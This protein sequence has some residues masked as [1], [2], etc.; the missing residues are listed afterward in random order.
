[1][2][3]ALGAFNACP[4]VQTI[5]IPR[6][7]SR[8][9]FMGFAGCG[10]LVDIILPDT[11]LGIG[12]RAFEGCTSLVHLVLPPLLTRI[13]ARLFAGCTN[14]ATI[15]LPRQVRE[16]GPE[17]FSNC[18]SLREVRTDAT[19]INIGTNAFL[20]ATILQFFEGLATAAAVGPFA[21]AD[22]M[23]CADISPDRGDACVAEDV[24]VFVVPVSLE[25][26]APYSFRNCGARSLRVSEA[27][28]Q[29]GTGAFSSN[30]DLWKLVIADGTISIGAAAFEGCTR[31]GSAT[32]PATTVSINSSAFH[33]CTDLMWV[34]FDGRQLP[35]LESDDAGQLAP[36]EE[37]CG[38]ISDESTGALAWNGIMAQVANCTTVRYNVYEHG[39]LHASEIC[40]A[41]DRFVRYA[42]GEEALA[43]AES[44]DIRYDDRQSA[45]ARADDSQTRKGTCPG[46]PA[47]AAIFIDDY[48]SSDRSTAHPPGVCET[49]CD[50]SAVYVQCCKA[51][52]D[53][54]PRASSRVACG[55]SDW[56]P[57]EHC[58]ETDVLV[59]RDVTSLVV[60]A[61]MGCASIASMTLPTTLRYIEREALRDCT[62]LA[63]IEIPASVIRI[64]DR[65]LFGCTSLLGVVFDDYTALG[66]EES[67][68]LDSAY[69]RE[70][71]GGSTCQ[72][73]QSAIDTATI[74]DGEVC[75]A[76]PTACSGV[77]LS[78]EF[79]ACGD[80]TEALHREPLLGQ[81][82]EE[83]NELDACIVTVR[84]AGVGTLGPEE[85]AGTS[86]QRFGQDSNLVITVS[87]LNL[88]DDT[89]FAT[90]STTTVNGIRS[91]GPIEGW[92]VSELPGYL[93]Q[94]CG[95]STSDTLTDT[96]DLDVNVYQLGDL[97][98]TDCEADCIATEDC[99]YF[100]VIK[101]PRLR[102]RDLNEERLDHCLL[103]SACPGK[104]YYAG[105]AL[106]R[107]GGSRTFA[108]SGNT[109]S[110]D[111]SGPFFPIEAISHTT[112]D[113]EEV[114]EMVFQQS[115]QSE[116]SV[117]A[118]G[119]TMSISIFKD[120]GAAVASGTTTLPDIT[121]ADLVDIR[122]TF[123]GARVTL[124][125]C[126]SETT[127]TQAALCTY[128][129]DSTPRPTCTTT[130]GEVVSV[131]SPADLADGSAALELTVG[132]DTCSA[133]KRATSRAPGH[134]DD[135]ADGCMFAYWDVGDCGPLGDDF[136]DPCLVQPLGSFAAN[137]ITDIHGLVG[138]EI[139]SSC[140]PGVGV[141]QIV[142]RWR[143]ECFGV[144]GAAGF[145]DLSNVNISGAIAFEC[146]AAD[147][148]CDAAR[149]SPE[150]CGYIPVRSTLSA[151]PTQ[152]PTGSPA[153]S[154]LQCY[155]TSAPVLAGLIGAVSNLDC[156]LQVVRLNDV[157]QFAGNVLTGDEPLGCLR[158]L[159]VTEDRKFLDGQRAT[160]VCTEVAT[161]IAEFTGVQLEC[162]QWWGDS[163]QDNRA[164]NVLRVPTDTSCESVIRNL[165]LIGLAADNLA[166]NATRRPTSAPTTRR[167][168]RA[169]T[170]TPTDS[171]ARFS[172]AG[173]DY[174]Y[175]TESETE[176]L[177]YR[178]VVTVNCE[179][180]A[181]RLRERVKHGVDRVGGFLCTGPNDDVV[182][183]SQDT[184]ATAEEGMLYST[185]CTR[186]AAELSDATD[187]AFVCGPEGPPGVRQFLMFT[188]ACESA[189]SRLNTFAADETASPTEIPT[190]RPTGSPI[191]PPTGSP[192]PFPSTSPTGQ[193][194]WSPTLSPTS[195]PTPCELINGV[196]E[197][198]DKLTIEQCLFA[199]RLGL[200]TDPVW[201]R[202][203]RFSCT[204]CTVAP[205]LSPT[206][207]PTIF[208]STFPSS[209]PSAS[210]SALPSTL[211]SM[212]PTTEPTMSPTE[213]GYIHARPDIFL[214]LFPKS[215][216][217]SILSLGYCSESTWLTRCS[218]TC[219]GCTAAPTEMPTTTPTKTP[220]ALPTVLPT[221]F[222][223]SSPTILP[224]RCSEIHTDP[225]F[226][227]IMD[228]ST[229]ELGLALGYCDS[230]PH[231][232]ANCRFTCTGC[233]NAPTLS[234]TTS[235]TSAP[236]KC[237][238]IANNPD[239]ADLLSLYSC[240]EAYENGFCGH[241]SWYDVCRWTCTGCTLGPTSSPT[242]S[243]TNAPSVTPTST[244]TGSPT[245]NP[246]P[247]PTNFPTI[248]PTSS[249]SLSPILAPSVFP[250]LSPS[251]V[252]TASPSVA[253]TLSPTQCEEI[254]G[255][256]D[257]SDIFLKT[258]CTR[259]YNEGRCDDITYRDVCRYTCTGCTRAPTALPT[260]FPS[261]LPSSSPTLSPSSTTT[262]TQTRTT[263]TATSLT[264]TSHTATVVTA[265]SVT[266]TSFTITSKTAT[267][268]TQ[269]TLTQTSMTATSRTTSI[270]ATVTSL[271]A[272]SKTA[273]A[274]TS[275][276]LTITS[277]TTSITATAT[278]LTATSKTATA[279]T[280]TSLT[281][282]S[283]T[284]TTLTQTSLSQTS[285]TATSMTA[286]PA[287]RR[288]RRG[289]NGPVPTVSTSTMGTRAR[290]RRQTA[291][292]TVTGL[293][294]AP[295]DDEKCL[296]AS[297]IGQI[298]NPPE[299]KR[300]Y[301][302][303]FPD[304][305]D[306]TLTDNTT[307]TDQFGS[308]LYS[309]DSWSAVVNEPGEWMQIDL[310]AELNIHALVFQSRNCARNLCS[311]TNPQ[312]V[313]RFTVN[314]SS[315]LGEGFTSVASV[316][317][318]D[319]PSGLCE[320]YNFGEVVQARYVRL[321]VEEWS[322]HIAMRAGVVVGSTPN[323]VLRCDTRA[324]GS[325]GSPALH[326]DEEGVLPLL[327]DRGCQCCHV[328]NL[329]ERAVGCILD[330]TTEQ[331]SFSGVRCYK[332]GGSSDRNGLFGYWQHVPDVNRDYA[333]I[334]SALA[335]FVGSI[336]G[337]PIGNPLP[338]ILNDT[339]AFVP[340]VNNWGG[341]RVLLNDCARNIDTLN[342]FIA[343]L[344]V[345]QT[346]LAAFAP[347]CSAPT[348]PF[349]ADTASPNQSPSL[350][351]TLTPSMFPTPCAGDTLQACAVIP[352]SAC[353]G[354]TAT[355]DES[356]RL[357][358]ESCPTLCCDT[359]CGPT[360]P[361]TLSPTVTP[362]SSPSCGANE[363]PDGVD[364]TICEAA[365]DDPIVCCVEL[366][367]NWCQS[368]CCDAPSCAASPTTPSP[369]PAPTS[370]P[371]KESVYRLEFEG[372]LLG[373]KYLPMLP[374]AALG[375]DVIIYRTSFETKMPEDQFRIEDT[376]DRSSP[377]QYVY[378]KLCCAAKMEAVYDVH[379]HL[380][381][382]WFQDGVSSTAGY[383][384]RILGN[385]PLFTRV[386]VYFFR[387]YRDDS[388][389]EV[390]WE[391]AA[392]G[393]EPE[394]DA[395][396]LELRRQSL[397]GPPTWQPHTTRPTS[398]PTTRSP[399]DVT[400]SP[401]LCVPSTTGLPSLLPSAAP[402]T[403]GPTADVSKTFAPTHPPTSVPSV[404]PTV[405]PATF[406]RTCTV[407]GNAEIGLGCGLGE[408]RS[409][410]TGWDA[411]QNAVN[412]CGEYYQLSGRLWYH[413]GVGVYLQ[414]VN[415][416]TLKLLD[417]TIGSD[418]YWIISDTLEANAVVHLGAC[419]PY[420]DSALAILDRLNTA[421]NDEVL[422][423]STCTH[424]TPAGCDFGFAPIT[425]GDAS[426]CVSKDEC[427]P[428][429]PGRSYTSAA[430]YCDLTCF[431]RKDCCDDVRTV[432]ETSPR[433][434]APSLS[435]TSSPTFC[436]PGYQDELPYETC[437]A[438]LADG[439]C[440][441]GSRWFDSCNRTCSGC[442]SLRPTSAPSSAP[443]PCA[444]VFSNTSFRDVLPPDQ[445]NSALRLGYCES[446]LAWYS[447]CNF[448]CTGCTVSPTTSPTMAPTKAPTLAPTESPSGS[449]SLS[450]TLSPTASPTTSP[451]GSPSLSP[452]AD[453][454]VN[455]LLSRDTTKRPK[456][457]APSQR[458]GMGKNH[459]QKGN[460]DASAGLTDDTNRDTTKRPKTAAPSQRIGMGE[461][462]RQKG[463][464][465]AS[466]GLTDDTNR[467]GGGDG[468][469]A[470]TTVEGVVLATIIMVSASLVV[471]GIV[472]LYKRAVSQRYDAASA[473]RTMNRLIAK[474]E[475]N[476]VVSG[477]ESGAE[478]DDDAI[479]QG[480][481][482][483]VWS[484]PQF[485][486]A[487]DAATQPQ[488][489]LGVLA[490]LD[491]ND[492][493]A[494]SRGGGGG[495]GEAKST[496]A[497]AL[498][499]DTP[500][501]GAKP[502]LHQDNSAGSILRL[503]TDLRSDL[504]C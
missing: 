409:Q 32:I 37:V 83:R 25:T 70:I 26:I 220:T 132:R 47:P 268:L 421:P 306:S 335:R 241:S 308:M 354:T 236:S 169:P 391:I 383:N 52:T 18:S 145:E 150:T 476:T 395:S 226:R 30:T 196:E 371:T 186:A 400:P 470:S 205:T 165:E 477:V 324:P 504:S 486:A 103:F 385:T 442:G 337:R 127:P 291:I 490:S 146:C 33:D 290:D 126:F 480:Y 457:A 14:L 99:A 307:L 451:S 90:G 92:L 76:S 199:F 330:R 223:T 129:T 483:T 423:G 465:D 431:I 372:R 491:A 3:L 135:V 412:F 379:W 319:D 419:C 232:L 413:E 235:P 283:R 34:E 166:F 316:S 202:N 41:G 190:G 108:V 344:A 278:S 340:L 66:P 359:V 327:C 481:I 489:K 257:F 121:P 91:R 12:D 310:G 425:C 498:R 297:G 259:V 357:V 230:H 401:T 358:R 432:C 343:N 347:A 7:V 29:I 4:L 163:E 65:A 23:V 242:T 312:R 122:T 153:P 261:M 468:R 212:S 417:G 43:C 287:L 345:D 397:A 188:Y 53:R 286:T 147:G 250:T 369:T 328:V 487:V 471:I 466:A 106:N 201:Y 174:T 87:Q 271:T 229:C 104:T 219:T 191:Q 256:P 192:T 171:D 159:V 5:H 243:P 331:Y 482:S 160:S 134:A 74:T 438:A 204:G 117:T 430:C 38:G 317:A 427:V 233:T 180:D 274:V 17:A 270:T 144:D 346:A 300:S 492:N 172:C 416:T 170:S 80:C 445:C 349:L 181:R 494:T 116:V 118:K 48:L 120:D 139:Y 458:I 281:I 36:F 239:F 123:G 187:L 288:H 485:S 352:S 496:P 221:G 193:P 42:C 6:T 24:S 97:F 88:V 71:F 455:V 329:L 113:S 456:T 495:S 73:I 77:G 377:K 414:R 54:S 304:E 39:P 114:L 155:N 355:I 266:Y 31:L 488:A 332:Q 448:T 143:D 263:A 303:L 484:D 10:N 40:T 62:N 472:L 418:I 314:V 63:R 394:A 68:R 264:A 363:V 426:T 130:V 422:D 154:E 194:T 420:A 284:A 258:D 252:P 370:A 368:A 367:A 237:E 322:G 224:T 402:S 35:Q 479:V 493:A 387:D 13:G 405:S 210:P 85:G 178:E 390:M 78:L 167:P 183:G 216:C 501:G 110:V 55:G 1:M 301:S 305:H 158:K 227:D 251:S 89:V 341:S 388:Q 440:D 452:T 338:R 475:A 443:T 20:G 148:T 200:C 213:C 119:I 175:A 254:D 57:S 211:P 393:E 380:H 361:P 435:P 218:F 474:Q 408:T 500:T 429:R 245:A 95:T 299:S 96:P 189:M 82:I 265:T 59:P 342:A 285:I 156:T 16:I 151:A 454:E 351:P 298:V 473:A 444:D 222:P 8:I 441:V 195:S 69:G 273:T 157:L 61:F 138:D 376:S 244:P 197:F 292:I 49:L 206:T 124:V 447:N 279:V 318:Q 81:I 497:A 84:Y 72:C 133:I 365:L 295:T 459:R 208:P 446:D 27:V 109:T 353:C 415:F 374:V 28:R 302:S 93:H 176:L 22:T 164:T 249:P 469:V 453:V 434:N 247:F 478:W 276:S 428:N 424:D 460:G 231:W 98:T 309:D 293:T 386:N 433:T 463:N 152:V 277:R 79:T 502:T 198:T 321:V 51:A 112:Q 462:H 75:P 439:D 209:S 280:S 253:P 381:E 234:P 217:V 336:N 238:T 392:V 467:N 323:I 267:S 19:S 282:T 15:T 228:P 294:V 389:D 107:A 334:N 396:V 262:T 140:C 398:A 464:G 2:P 499:S 137:H 333:E 461:N 269:T 11:L 46:F 366:L 255:H 142:N 50:C 58:A 125:D 378:P 275:T 296:G 406:N 348:P 111:A 161:R 45:Y 315:D 64:G 60:R 360:R 311:L 9:G 173:A 399:T 21:F 362:T 325:G 56:L 168:S 326:G 450:P 375:D 260:A 437:L 136:R 86:R 410:S 240:V 373:E 339:D 207:A 179:Q 382:D 356:A 449:P 215:D 289:V 248:S 407:T 101:A 149:R 94:R 67:A 320:L 411:Q 364:P 404:S 503:S 272:T 403:R 350:S 203:C 214:D 105:S 102:G 225:H 384:F 131:R 246:A 185:D 177:N 44:S 162:A 128:D 184:N 100:T 313:T 115:T 436:A 182:I 141:S